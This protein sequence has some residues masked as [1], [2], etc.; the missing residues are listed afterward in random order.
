MCTPGDVVRVEGG[1]EK[2]LMT[3]VRGVHICCESQHRGS[4]DAW[5]KQDHMTQQSL[6]S[7]LSAS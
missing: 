3:E 7:G 4:R 1:E 5:M 2:Y 6:L